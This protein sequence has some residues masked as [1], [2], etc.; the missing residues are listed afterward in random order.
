MIVF[1]KVSKIYPPDSAALQDIS[2]H[3]TEG[4]FVSLVGK[5]GAGK[6]TLLELFLREKFPSV[7]TVF[8]Q[9]EN[10]HQIPDSRLPEFRRKVGVVFQDYKL[11]PH[12]TAYE[13]IAYVMEVMGAREQDI[14]RDVSEVLEIVGLLE[15]A[16][17]YPAQLSGGERQRVAIARALIHRPDVI[18]ADEPTGNL[19]PYHTRDIIGLLVKINELGTTIILAT[20]NKEVINRL[21]K[22]VI[23]LDEGRMVRDE[24]RGKFMI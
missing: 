3:I 8:F 20:H 1:E 7:G 12:K 23:T 13:N 5:S 9:G 6:S 14:V 15:R 16:H 17:H 24:E 4:E 22:R 19:D 10:V 18:C 11:L 21:G 2:F